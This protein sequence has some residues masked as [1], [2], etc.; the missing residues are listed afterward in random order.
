[1]IPYGKHFID[2][3]DI[4]AVIRCLKS[5]LITQGPLVGQFEKQFADFVGAKYAVAVSSGTAAL[6]LSTA[7]S[8]FRKNHALVTSSLTF[9]ASANVAY[10]Q[11]GRIL[12]TDINRDTLTMD[13]ENVEQLL[14]QH[15]DIDLLIPVHFGGAPCDME[16]I[17]RLAK[18]H[19]CKIIEDASHALG[20]TYYNGKKVGSCC[21][22]DMTTFSF[23]PVKTI[24]TG[25][26]GM[27]T[28][29]DK[30]LY[31]SL[32]RLRSHGIN[33]ADD[34]YLIQDQAITD[35]QTNPW[36]YEMQDLGF[37]YRLTDFQSALGISQLNKLESFLFRRRNLAAVYDEAFFNEAHIVL[38]QLSL[39][40]LSGM[41]L[42][43]L[44]IDFE[45]L[46]ISRA[47]FMSK[48]KADGIGSQV[49]YIPL[50][51]HPFYKEK[52]FLVQDYPNVERYYQ[53]CLSI[54]LFFSLS[55][56][57]QQRVVNAIKTLCR[58]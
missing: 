58:A 3:D 30:D 33:K 7:A 18:S 46:G 34:S 55:D 4:D 47:E 48:L 42:Y 40:H 44:Q 29:N 35:G 17:S 32:L 31:R 14:E 37:N 36:Y 27:I 54:P 1:M 51:R 25:E 6:H 19:G 11:N 24:A 41:H 28:T 26:G 20:A 52:G 13:P 15:S 39:R 2:D 8:G 5:G 56:Q 57:E 21:Y 53:R 23:H 43:V 12:L 50:P 10:Y 16:E 22:C 49:H 38:P 45:E 9:V